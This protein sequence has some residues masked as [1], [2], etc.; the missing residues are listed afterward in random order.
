MVGIRP[1]VDSF[2]CL[3]DSFDDNS[4]AVYGTI[5]PYT[6]RELAHTIIILVMY[7]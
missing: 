7:Y 1:V 3:G 2:S 4:L 5:V 6:A